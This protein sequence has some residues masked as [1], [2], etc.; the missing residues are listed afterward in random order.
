MAKIYF[1]RREH[2][3]IVMDKAVDLAAAIQSMK[4]AAQYT[5]FE[6]KNAHGIVIIV[7]DEVQYITE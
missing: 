6:C 5:Y 7:L 1:K 3:L 2:L 4:T